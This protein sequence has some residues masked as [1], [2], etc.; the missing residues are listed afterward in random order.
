MIPRPSRT[1]RRRALGTS[2]TGA[3]AAVTGSPSAEEGLGAGPVADDVEGVQ[4]ARVAG[5]VQE[6]GATLR[7]ALPD[8][9]AIVLIERRRLGLDL[10]RQPLAEARE[11]LDRARPLGLGLARVR[12]V[13]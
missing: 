6:T 9:P 8:P 3:D 2:R 7:R 1:R 4:V 5:D 13:L 12:V 11:L 10:V